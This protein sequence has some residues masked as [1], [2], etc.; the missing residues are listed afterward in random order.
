MGFEKVVLDKVAKVLKE[1]RKACF[2]N[3]SL[4]VECTAKDAARVET[5]L[6]ELTQG[7]VIVSSFKQEFVYDFVA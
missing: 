7:G 1:E 4:F 2:F 6:I 5:A 3:G